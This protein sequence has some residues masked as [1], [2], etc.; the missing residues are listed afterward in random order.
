ME[1]YRRRVEGEIAQ[2]LGWLVE[3][4]EVLLRLIRT[5]QDT[6]LAEHGIDFDIAPLQALLEELQRV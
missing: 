6:I 1:E 4:G 2:S 3:E 5:L